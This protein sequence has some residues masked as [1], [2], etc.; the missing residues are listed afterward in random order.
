MK[1]ETFTD[2][3][4]NFREKETKWKRFLEIIGK[5]I[6]WDEWADFISPYYL[7]GKRGHPLMKVEKILFM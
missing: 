4:Y 6:P 3:E 7:R 1:Q 5:S 2:L